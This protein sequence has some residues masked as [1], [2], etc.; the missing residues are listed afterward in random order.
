MVDNNKKFHYTIN[1]IMLFLALFCVLPF[2]LMFVSSVTDE[3]ALVRNGYSFWPEA[4]SFQ[5]YVHLLAK[6]N[7]ILSGYIMT[8]LVTGIGTTASILMTILLAYPL[9][10]KEIPGRNKIMFFVFFT[11]L[12]NGGMVPQYMMWS[13]LFHIKDSIWALILPNLLMNAF[14][15]I[16]MRTYFATN[17]QDALLEA[18][19]IDG[20]GEFRI[21][22]KIVMPLSKPM[23]AAVGLMIGL[24]YWND[25]INGLY[26]ITDSKYYSIQNILNRML[27][28]AAFLTSGSAGSNASELANK[29]PSVGIKMAV[30]VIG[31]LPI[32]IIY[33][34]VQKNLV[35]GI[36]IG[37]VKG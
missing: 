3:S 15:I 24:G 23:I 25:W 27:A 18:A 26:Y 37:G 8:V 13:N 31:V 36:T 12:F 30:A 14:Y 32:M 2:F 4:F 20:A 16:M 19:R 5:A 35:K 29:I 9:S 17:I 34:F 6:S 7:K 28:D 11:M 33:P 21:L 10:R 1:V 22:A